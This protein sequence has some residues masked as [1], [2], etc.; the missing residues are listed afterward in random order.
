M[1]DE[2]TIGRA[3]AL[4]ILQSLRQL[5]IV[6]I[7]GIMQDCRADQ[8]NIAKKIRESTGSDKPYFIGGDVWLDSI[9]KQAE[10]AKRAHS[11][12]VAIYHEL[13]GLN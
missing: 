3:T 9:I 2:I 13:M 6:K 1:E 11:E 4:E 10:S 5:Y 8:N 7:D 12:Q